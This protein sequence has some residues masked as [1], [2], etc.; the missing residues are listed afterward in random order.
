MKDDA[1]FNPNF[2]DADA[3][4]AVEEEDAIKKARKTFIRLFEAL[5]REED[6]Q[7]AKE[8]FSYSLSEGK[9][10]D[11][12]FDSDRLKVIKKVFSKS[13]EKLEEQEFTSAD[14]IRA[15]AF[16]MLKA[17]GGRE[18][19]KGI[20][21]DSGREEPTSLDEAP[22][23]L[24]QVELDF[25]PEK[26]GQNLVGI[27]V[28]GG[29]SSLTPKEQE[30]LNKKLFDAVSR[31]DVSLQEIEDLYYRGAQVNATF[32]SPDFDKA[33]SKHETSALNQAIAAGNYEIA[34]FL[35]QQ[36]ADPNAKNLSTA[37]I[38]DTNPLHL[39]AMRG[40][41][42]AVEVL[43]KYG[44]DQNP[45]GLFDS[46]PLESMLILYSK[47]KTRG[48]DTRGAENLERC[49]ELFEASGADIQQ[50]SQNAAEQGCFSEEEAADLQSF[51]S[52][53]SEKKLAKEA[54]KK[55][56]AFT[57][58]IKEASGVIETFLN[59]NLQR[60]SDENVSPI[61]PAQQNQARSSIPVR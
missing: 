43:L 21:V 33:G 15:E 17:R 42:Q 18:K 4:Q 26:E 46:T 25:L 20:F 12:D 8:G 9:S 3:G 61:A 60:S 27:S 41:S 48:E 53:Y 55:H 36:H 56:Q 51:L 5:D 58:S 34:E 10:A 29:E 23:E 47:D 24:D 11:Y 59:Q 28:S 54:D 52:S 57:D 31:K 44:A 30:A 14:E 39:A 7:S 49:L 1:G 13:G 35:L 37:G 16:A 45:G 50:A 38:A 19:F 40:D 22:L 32:A 6:P 2:F